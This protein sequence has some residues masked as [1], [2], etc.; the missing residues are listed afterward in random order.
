MKRKALCLAAA[1]DALA[2]PST[3]DAAGCTGASTPGP[4]NTI[5]VDENPAYKLIKTTK[6]GKLYSVG[7]GDDALNVRD[8]LLC[9][10]RVHSACAVAPRSLGLRACSVP[11]AI[12]ETR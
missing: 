9:M 12:H 2:V 7:T 5:P 11:L 1:A 4:P 8:W 6:N 3:V 10:A